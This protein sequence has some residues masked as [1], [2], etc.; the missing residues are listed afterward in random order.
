MFGWLKRIILRKR[1]ATLR[2]RL[3]IKSDGQTIT[4]S[5]E[6]LTAEEQTAFYEAVRQRAG[7]ATFSRKIE[8]AYG[9]EYAKQTERCPRCQQETQKQY[10]EFLYLTD[11]G[12]RA[13]FAPAGYFCSHCPTVIV[14]E[15]LIRTGITG[16]YHYQ[17]TMGINDATKDEPTLFRTWNGGPPMF[18]LRNLDDLSYDAQSSEPTFSE[19]K[20]RK[21]VNKRKMQRASRKRNRR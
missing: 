1:A 12:V 14:D 15:A 4:L 19:S 20:Y 18:G 5:T 13:M 16:N 3:Q 6:N 17:A 11:E 21:L 2:E 8:H 10:A 9:K 7:V